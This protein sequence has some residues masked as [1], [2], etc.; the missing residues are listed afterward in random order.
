MLDN[1]VTNISE[2]VSSWLFNFN[3]ALSD[4]NNRDF[5]IKV[6]KDLFFDDSH[7]R[8]IL[9]LTWKIQTFSG[10]ENII[11]LLYD[12]LLDYNADSF[13]VNAERTA[14]EKL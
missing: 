14:L 1:H 8:D 7:W 6:L 12:S 2:E 13:M 3:E 4:R 11:Q 9:A 10:S 5:S